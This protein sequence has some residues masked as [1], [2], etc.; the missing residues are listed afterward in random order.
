MVLDIKKTFSYFNEQTGESVAEIILVGGSS[1]LKGLADYFN[2]NFGIPTKIGEQISFSAK[3][4]SASVE[5][6]NQP[7]VYIEALGLAL[8]G[9]DEKWEKSDPAI[10]PIQ[11]ERQASKTA[12]SAGRVL[13]YI[14]SFFKSSKNRVPEDDQDDGGRKLHIQKII[15][16]VLLAVA[17]VVVPAS[18]WYKGYKKTE[19]QEEVQLRLEAIDAATQKQ[20]A[21]QKTNTEP[22]R[23]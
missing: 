14:M 4:N 19:Q 5:K 21:T 16:I 8:R 15:F 6:S 18:Y 23:P 10:L 13:S 20:G 12:K 9:V 1:V 3:G 11:K 17:V 22:I 7:L 2:A